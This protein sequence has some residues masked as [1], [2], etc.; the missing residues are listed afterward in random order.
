M[1]EYDAIVV[2]AG[3]AGLSCAVRLQEEGLNVKVY[4]MRDR[5]GGRIWSERED[6][7]I[8]DGG[9]QVLHTAYP[10]C[11]R[12][13]DYK[14][15]ALGEYKPGAYVYWRDTIHDITDPWR[16]P[17]SFLGS[18]ISP[19]GTFK[20]KWVLYKY[21]KEVLKSEIHQIYFRENVSALDRLQQLG[22]SRRLIE[23][24]FRPFFSGVFLEKDLKTSSRVLDFLFKMM[25]EGAAAIPRQGMAAIPQQMASK[26]AP[27]TVELNT[28]I[29]EI[30]PGRVELS[31]GRSVT[32]DSIAVAVPYTAVTTL[33]K[34]MVFAKRGWC[35]TTAVYYEAPR[36]PLKDK[37]ILLNSGAGDFISNVSVPS[38]VQPSYAPQ[39]K[40]LVC[41]SMTGAPDWGEV[42]SRVEK[43]LATL[44]P[45]DFPEWTLRKVYHI[46]KALPRQHP[47]DMDPIERIEALEPGFYMCGDHLQTSSIEGAMSSGLRAAEAMI[48]E[49]KLTAD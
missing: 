30:E 49:R 19:I 26:L 29:F 3:V 9:F 18:L 33:I 31:R 10:T 32:A 46:P 41:V 45:D 21:R 38:D 2:G 7:F 37:K 47:I 4:E 40:S 6:G 25:T 42:R 48:K 35:G 12:C 28:E 1:A 5:V 20:D 11:Q 13:L 23:Q 34:G 15:L 27:G 39:G 22:F 24:F 16:E 36:S 14:A 17:A 44:F 43:D 8:Y